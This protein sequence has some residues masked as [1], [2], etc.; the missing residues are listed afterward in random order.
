[1]EIKSISDF[2]Q[3]IR[4]GPYAFP[5]GYP[6]FFLMADGE[7]CSFKALKDKSNRRVILEALRDKNDKQ[8]QPIYLHINYEG[9]LTCA[10][11]NEPIERAYN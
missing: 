1:M 9:D 6:L 10:H 5:G 11:T 4:I 3:V 2:R 8:W 7:T